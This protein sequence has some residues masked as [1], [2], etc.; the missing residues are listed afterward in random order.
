[1]EKGLIITYLLTYGGA[2]LSL[3]N[4]F[5][6]LLIYICFAI[7]KPESLW[8]W[9]VPAGN[10]SRIVGIALLVG[11]TFHGFGNWRF[12]RAGAIVWCAVGYWLWMVAATFNTPVGAPAWDFVESMGKVI[13]PF[14]VGMT[15]IDS[16]AKLKLLAWVILLSHAYLAF[17]FNFSYLEGVNRLH[18]YGFAGMDNNCAAIGLVTC[19]GLAFF[20]SL[21]AQNIWL[22][23]LALGSVALMVHA[24]LFSYSRGGLLGLIVTGFVSFLLIPKQAKHYLLFALTVGLGVFMAG[25]SVRERF[26]TS[27]AESEERDLAAQNR[28]DY[29]GFAVDLMRKEPLFGVGPRQFADTLPRVYG[30]TRAEAHNLWLQTGAEIGIPGLGFLLLFYGISATRLWSLMRKDNLGVD[31]EYRF[32]ARMVLASLAGFVVST[33]F[34][35]MYGLEVPYYVVLIGA[36][37]LKLASQPQIVALVEYS[38]AEPEAAENHPS[39]AQSTE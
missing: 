10:Y 5:I 15:L 36:G 13:L 31:A 9:S 2:V 18:D 14:V 25:P 34:V 19:V 4:P 20:L 6:G 35:S 17:E 39:L 29:W 28:V 26:E 32:L 33:Q 37:A 24:V 8:H 21:H 38:Q 30:R 27:F 16:A 3:F 12:G 7:I 23:L 1:M 11:W 22:K